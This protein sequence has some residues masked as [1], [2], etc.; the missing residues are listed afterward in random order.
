VASERVF[1]GAAPVAS[2]R[3]LVASSFQFYLTGDEYL[4]VEALSPQVIDTVVDIGARRWREADRSIQVQ[5]ER[6]VT[7][8]LLSVTRAEY[9]LDAGAFLNLR[10][11]TRSTGALLGRLFVRAQLVTGAGDAGA[12]VGTLLQ[13]YI[14]PENDRAWPGSP[15]ET[16]HDSLGATIRPSGSVIN[17]TNLIYI[18]PAGV[19]WRVMAGRALFVASAAVANRNMLLEVFD[20]S[21][22]ML[23]QS[24]NG[25]AVAA[26]VAAGFS[27]GAGLSFSND[28]SLTVTYLSMPQDLDL[29][30][31]SVLQLRTLNAQLGDVFSSPAL[32]VREWLDQ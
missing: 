21:G 27:F 5:R 14:S 11:S 6:L 3:G 7:D 20:P 8:P 1:Q 19:R 30:A 32:W 10:L 26:G 13:G 31:G 24:T 9:P 2:G 4:R 23:W 29:L 28:A 25:Y 22:Q 15:I 12:V 17:P 18:V 16:M